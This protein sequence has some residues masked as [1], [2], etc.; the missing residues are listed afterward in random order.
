MN[1]ETIRVGFRHTHGLKVIQGVWSDCRLF[2]PPAGVNV[3]EYAKELACK[4]WP[5]IRSGTYTVE[6]WS[7]R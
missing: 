5:G 1:S 6:V 4:S 7:Q 2:T 3:N